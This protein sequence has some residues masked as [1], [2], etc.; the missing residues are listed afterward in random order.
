MV[1]ADIARRARDAAPWL[2]A[3]ALLLAP[4]PARAAED[5]PPLPAPATVGDSGDAPSTLPVDAEKP[6]AEKNEK[7]TK[8]LPPLVEKIVV[9]A[10]TAEEGRDAATFTNV[11]REEIAAR[12]HGQDLA[13]ILADTPNAYAYSDAGNG[14]GYSYLSIRGF[15]QERIATYIDGIP[16]NTPED[17]ALYFIDLADLAGGLASLQ[18]Q[19]GTGTALYGSPAVG[20]AVQL[21]TGHLD[22]VEGGELKLGAGSFGTRRLDF[23]YGG[24][25]AGGTW[26]WMARVAH[27][28]SDGYRVP[29]WTRHTLFHFALERFGHD[30]VLRI[31][32]F[33]GPERT[34]LSYYGVPIEYLRGEITGNAGR[35]RRVNPMAP[36]E[37]DQFVQ[38]HLHLLHDWKIADGLFLHNAAYAV[39]NDGYFLQHDDL[40][41]DYVTDYNPDGSPAAVMPVEDA[42][43]KRWIGGRDIGW[44]P[45]LTWDH[46]GGTLTAGLFVQDHSLHHEGSLRSGLACTSGD[47]ADPCATTEPLDGDKKLYDYTNS[48]QTMSVFARETVR[49]APRLALHFEAQ[50]TRHRFSMSDDAIRGLA[51]S[52]V[53]T[54]FAPRLGVNW[55][56]TDRLGFYATASTV[57][58]EPTFANVW[59]PE[60]PWS[61]PA[62]AFR[63]ASPSGHTFTDPAARPEKLR[64]LE[65]GATWRSGAAHFKAA[66]YEMRFRDEFV[67]QGGLDQNGLPITINAG[68]SLHRGIEFEAA[69]KLPG[70]VDVSAYA[71]A[72]R[73]VLLSF[74]LYGTGPS[75]EPILVDYSGNRIAGFPEGTARLRLSRPFGPARV[76]LGARWIGRIHLDNSE[77]ERKN[78]AKRLAPGYVTKRIDPFAIVDAQ[79]TIDLT[80]LVAGRGARLRFDL[81][82]DNLLD[83]EYVAMGYSYPSADFSSSYTEFFPAATRSFLAGLTFGF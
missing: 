40:Y 2:L 5:A 61:P 1:P 16:L 73:D 30:Q 77:N 35:D 43:R 4:V 76:A 45:R 53:Y 50:A 34:Q 25:I 19:R 80:R 56:P 7:K 69:G 64:D 70:E 3:A 51:W 44:V 39:V 74:T 15:R 83:R 67:P 82:I 65:A 31:Q 42:W 17:H 78:P 33:G 66:V 10:T 37:T 46:G 71:A 52:A 22:P 12:D 38:P 75:G 58:S 49:P 60:D 36:G 9:T 57:E 8:K 18:V 29:S 81:S 28:E 55:N 6:A 13:M 54:F 26:A 79:A 47:L 48:K 68:R 72:S 11:T 32:L 41:G 24:P 14:I 23:R 27:V 59:N 63:S 20:G 62:G 21:E